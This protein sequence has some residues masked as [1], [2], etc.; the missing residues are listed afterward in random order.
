M[1]RTALNSL[2][3]LSNW[4]ELQGQTQWT[5]FSGHHQKM[6]Q[7]SIIHKQAAANKDKAESLALLEEL[8]LD[9]S[10]NGG[11]FTVFIPI[12]GSKGVSQRLSINVPNQHSRNAAV[13]GISSVGMIPES[14]VQGMINAAL[15]KDRLIRE[16]EDLRAAMAAN[17]SIGERITDRLFE[18]SDQLMPAINALVGRL[19]GMIPQAQP[20]ALQGVQ[21][22]PPSPMGQGQATSYNYEA[23]EFL[24]VFNSIRPH[25]A[26]DR[27]FYDFLRG[28]SAYFL[29][30]PEQIKAM[31]LP[32]AQPAPQPQAEAQHVA[33]E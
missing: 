4:F 26:S 28:V 31:I 17:Q 10:Q 2:E 22:N 16:N 33:H 27:E 24:P 12:S 29:Q 5:L 23:G 18:H 32:Q 13:S 19:V 6:P 20:I 3:S 30:S 9:A 8:I 14:R 21:Q 25:F 1:A 15:E 11:H 7:H